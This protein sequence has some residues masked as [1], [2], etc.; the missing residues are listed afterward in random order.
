LFFDVLIQKNLVTI[1]DSQSV[2]QTQRAECLRAGTDTYCY[3]FHF[4]NATVVKAIQKLGN[5]QSN[6]SELKKSYGN[7]FKLLGF[8]PVNDC[9]YATKVGPKVK[10]VIDCSHRHDP[11]SSLHFDTPIL[12]FKPL[13]YVFQFFLIPDSDDISMWI[14]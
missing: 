3:K 10:G 13:P 1:L 11:E 2:Q 4:S 5:Y 9:K 8:V 12:H 14:R 6:K 7:K